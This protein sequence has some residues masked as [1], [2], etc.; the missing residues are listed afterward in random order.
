MS[1]SLP[2]IIPRNLVHPAGE[3]DQPEVVGW[4]SRKRNRAK[5]YV[6]SIDTAAMMERTCPP[7]VNKLPGS[8]L[9]G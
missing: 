8:H 9:H 3:V 7:L 5:A 1:T 4:S 6:E 2:L